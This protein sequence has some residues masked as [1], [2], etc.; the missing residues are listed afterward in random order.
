MNELFLISLAILLK[1]EGFYSNDPVDKG[2]E[3]YRGISRNNFPNWLGW[4]IV[5]SA[6]D[7]KQ[8]LAI[9]KANLKLEQL[10]LDFYYAE[11]WLKM[12]CD[13]IADQSQSIASELFELSVHAGIARATIILQTTLN[14]LN[15]N[16]KLYPDID[17]DGIF[18]NDTLAVLQT[19]FSKQSFKRIFNVINI[20]QG[21]FYSELMLN[22]PVY[23][24]YIGWF[25]RVV[26]ER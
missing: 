20:L 6:K 26:I 11:F 15:N 21:A 8:F 24:K 14:I 16:Q 4:F 3:T 19:A 22:N 9:L 18:G 10:V 23:E 7:S 25:D 1:F 2:G 17:T 13:L 12:N 5:D